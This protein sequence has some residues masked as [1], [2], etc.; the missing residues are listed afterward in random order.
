M[1]SRSIA[2]PAGRPERKATSASPWDSPAVKNVNV[3]FD[4]IRWRPLDRL[5]ATRNSGRHPTF[6]G[7][8]CVS[9]G[10]KWVVRMDITASPLR[11]TLRLH[12][13]RP[14]TDTLR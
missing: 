14:D 11:R 10:S 12:V 2:S 6:V 9:P 13:A 7:E 1:Y 4:C 5:W 8:P 3:D